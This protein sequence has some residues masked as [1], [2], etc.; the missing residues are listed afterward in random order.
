MEPT[1]EDLFTVNGITIDLP[2]FG[3]L[4]HNRPIDIELPEFIPGPSEDYVL[5]KYGIT[6]EEYQEIAER[7]KDT[8]YLGLS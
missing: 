7:L 6:E 2:D 3:T 5:K 1:L 4:I 8:W